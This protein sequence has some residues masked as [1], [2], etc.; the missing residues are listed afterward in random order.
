VL[1]AIGFLLIKQLGSAS[2]YYYN[3]DQ[4]VAHKAQLGSH[5]FRIQ[6]TFEGKETNLADG[7]VKFSIVF[8]GAKVLVDHSG[9]QPALFQ[10]GI[11]VVLDGRWSTD[12]SEF[13]SDQIEVKH[14]ATYIAKHPGRVNPDSQ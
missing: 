12:G 3:A 1:G 8:N 5:R 4:A 10:P 6:G 7:D 2:L 14:S 11:Q 9:S 13:L